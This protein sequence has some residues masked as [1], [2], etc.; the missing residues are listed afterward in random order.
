MPRPGGYG[1]QARLIH[2]KKQITVKKHKLYAQYK[3]ALQAEA[4]NASASLPRWTVHSEQQGA[5]GAESGPA[6]EAGDEA[7]AREPPRRKQ[8]HMSSAAT[9]RRK[10]ER[11]QEK[12]QAARQAE[13]EAREE[14]QRQQEAAR[15]RRS[16]QTANLNK[17]NK[18]GQPVLG[19]EVERLLGTLQRSK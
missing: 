5:A 13:E 1:G 3:K 12:V 7:T 18:R 2:K 19:F 6:A 11:E 8:K 15:R 4:A 9:Q 16:Q 17:R 10:W 14:R